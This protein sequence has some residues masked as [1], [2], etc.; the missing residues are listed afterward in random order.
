MLLTFF[1]LNIILENVIQ[2]KVYKIYS[3]VDVQYTY[4]YII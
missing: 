3:Q 4:Y 1:K 2:K